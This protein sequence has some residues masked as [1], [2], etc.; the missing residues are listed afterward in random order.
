MNRK[1]ESISDDSLIDSIVYTFF[2]LF[3]LI[4]NTSATSWRPSTSTSSKIGGKTAGR[5]RRATSWGRGCALSSSRCAVRGT[6]L[7]RNALRA[8]ASRT[9]DRRA[10]ATA[11]VRS[12]TSHS[13]DVSQVWKEE[14]NKEW[15]LERF[16]FLE[17]W[18]GVSERKSQDPSD[19]S[20]FSFS[21]IS[22]I[23]PPVFVSI[24]CAICTFLTPPESELHRSEEQQ[25]GRFQVCHQV[26]DQKEAAI[27][28][29]LSPRWKPVPS[30]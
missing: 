13:S 27:F 21:Q 26:D 8:P 1:L 3:H 4:R 14:E 20:N 29:I 17:Q 5:R 30:K 28:H 15:S 7:A 16:A 23:F 12:V 9:A 22:N 11:F 25:E 6:T 10:A 19:G 2:L 24:V 18:S